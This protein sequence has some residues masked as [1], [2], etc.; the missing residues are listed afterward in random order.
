[1]YFLHPTAFC[2]YSSERRSFSSSCSPPTTSCYWRLLQ[3]TLGVLAHLHNTIPGNTHTS[4]ITQVNA[5][6]WS[7]FSINS[8][9]TNQTKE[10]TNMLCIP[11]RNKQ[12]S[13]HRKKTDRRRKETRKSLN[14]HSPSCIYWNSMVPGGFWVTTSQTTH[15]HHSSKQKP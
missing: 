10:A 14:S 9:S 11:P 4:A 3:W 1:M 13:Q 7:G 6:E 15:Q 2:H 12:R 5:I 8:I